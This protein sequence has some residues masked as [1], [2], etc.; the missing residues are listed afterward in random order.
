MVYVLPLP[1]CPS[2]PGGMMRG[3]QEGMCVVRSEGV[4]NVYTEICVYKAE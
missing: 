2:F 4:G 3:I 1:C